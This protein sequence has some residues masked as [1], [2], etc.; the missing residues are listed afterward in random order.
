MFK[1]IVQKL[2]MEGIIVLIIIAILTIGVTG[3]LVYQY[4][5]HAFGVTKTVSLQ[6]YQDASLT[7]PLTEIDW[8]T[9]G[10]SENKTLHGYVK[11]T[12]TVPVFLSLSLANWNPSNAQDF[13]ILT[14][15]LEGVQL[16]IDRTAYA[17]FNLNVLP[18]IENITTFSFDIIVTANA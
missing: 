11:N 9:L 7:I 5:I 6:V 13:L 8:G 2:E 17:S 15:D 12:S 3:A 10:P 4:T 1:G 16:D 14:W 18:N